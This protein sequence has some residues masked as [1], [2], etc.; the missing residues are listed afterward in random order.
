MA[1]IREGVKRSYEYLPGLGLGA[2]DGWIVL[3]W[4]V[5]LGVFVSGLVRS[6][7]LCT[8]GLCTVGLCTVG[9]GPR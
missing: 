8:V 9:L 7:G 1:E 4:F 3:A 2:L 5:G 6:V